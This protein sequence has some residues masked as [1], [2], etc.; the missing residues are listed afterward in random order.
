MR[1][2]MTVEKQEI[3]DMLA[4]MK[5][6]ARRYHLVFQKVG[7]HDEVRL[8]PDQLDAKNA[9]GMFLWGPVNW[10]LEHRGYDYTR[11]E[12][13]EPITNAAG[14]I[15]RSIN[16]IAMGYAT[17]GGEIG[18]P[19]D[20]PLTLARKRWAKMFCKPVWIWWYFKLEI[21]PEMTLP[22]YQADLAAALTYLHGYYEG[23]KGINCARMEVSKTEWQYD[24]S[25]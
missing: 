4:P 14:F 25:R 16:E 22:T 24:V 17:V 19:L 18:A 6:R 15:V 9:E 23:R 3:L 1:E 5:E 12:F 7:M 21:M 11:L 20:A 13:D 8:T 2:Q 10:R